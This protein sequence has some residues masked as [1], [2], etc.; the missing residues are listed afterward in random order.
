MET[1]VLDKKV[2]VVKKT[3]AK[4][5]VVEAP[6]D[7][8]FWEITD[9]DSEGNYIVK[10]YNKAKQKELNELVGAAKAKLT[11]DQK[12][13]VVQDDN[14]AELVD[15]L[16]FEATI[17]MFSTAGKA[18][19]YNVK[20]ELI[21]DIKLAGNIQAMQDGKKAKTD[22]KERAEKVVKQEVIVNV[23][24]LEDITL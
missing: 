9:V 1:A 8:C 5:V 10:V 12:K 18:Y 6:K 23:E 15:I 13:R 16:G 17:E 11:K 20:K 21:K 2:E 24:E 7:K 3:K 4:A 19:V 22:A 14:Y